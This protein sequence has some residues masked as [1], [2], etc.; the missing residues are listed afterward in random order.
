MVVSLWLG[1]LQITANLS[2]RE[3]IDFSMAR[4]VGSLSIAGIPPDRVIAAFAQ[5]QAAVLT[6]VPSDV[7]PFHASTC[8]GSRLQCDSRSSL[9]AGS[10]FAYCIMASA[11]S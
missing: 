10:P 7:E 6:E 11:D 9:R 2:G 5:K 1:N 3:L 4:Q 8:N